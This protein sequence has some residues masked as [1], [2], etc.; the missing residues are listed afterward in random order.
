[1]KSIKTK[2]AIIISV[3]VV[4]GFIACI[5]VAATISGNKLRDMDKECLQAQAYRYG[6]EMNGWV[7]QERILTEDTAA[8]IALVGEVNE[9]Q[10]KKILVSNFSERPELLDMYFGAE[11]GSFWKASTASEVPEG[12]DPRERGWYKSAVEKGT[13]VVTDPYFDA[14]TLQMCDTIAVPV[15]VNDKLIGVAGIDMTID[16][17]TGVA[18]QISYDDGVYAFITDGS[19]NFI[20]HP[21]EEYMPTEDEAVSAIKEISEAKS[22]LTDVTKEEIVT[23]NDYNDDEVYIATAPISDANW[24][25]GIALPT[26]NAGKSIMKMV[27]AI[28]LVACI[29]LVFV[30]GGLVI[31]IRIMLGPINKMK[32]S[33]VKLAKGE[34]AI[35]LDRS[36]KKDE[37]S[38]LQNALCDLMESISDMIRDAGDALQEI[39]N[40][41]LTVEDMNEYPGEFNK[42]SESVNQIKNTLGH[43]IYM[44]K[45]ASEEVNV[46]S[47]NLAMAAE[48]LATATV[49]ESMNI[50]NLKDNV[51]NISTKINESSKNCNEVNIKLSELGEEIEN[52]NNAMSELYEAV[53]LVENT[54]ADIQKIVGA[55]DSIA[56]QTNILALN[57]SVEAARAGD[58]GKGFAVVAEE[59]RNLASKSAEESSKT[60]ELIENCLAAIAKAKGFAENATSC[61]NGVVEHSKYISGAFEN[62]AVLAQEEANNANA[63][64]SEVD[65]VS[66]SVNSNS[67]T[68]Q[69][70][71]ASSE[72]LTT[73]ADKLNQMVSTFKT[74]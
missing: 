37:V 56:F 52:G 41:N 17:I 67:A 15:Y 63:I 22:I 18:S 19:G 29:A 53:S 55:I 34:L 43:L 8:S 10:I 14:F 21:N 2:F 51:D 30:I 47:S 12:Y 1:M 7:R 54:S 60:A 26:A 74:N 40:G 35:K 46:G 38:V 4:I 62:I 23:S 16:T 20:Y 11:D 68:A 50:Q 57:A 42:L 39:A 69:Q 6:S 32:D 58:K 72:E 70:T 33:A 36:T 71:A 5:A 45:Q 73:Q 24:T 27:R 28:I 3:L 44:V 49:N 13:T 25:I 65:N 59:V 66:N 9:E 48:S 61:M 64:L 31:Q